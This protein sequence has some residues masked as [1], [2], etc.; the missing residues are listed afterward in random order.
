MYPRAPAITVLAALLAAFAPAEARSQAAPPAIPFAP[1]EDKTLKDPDNPTKIFRVD[2]AEVEYRYPLSR[3]DLMKIT[4]EN[5]QSLQ[6]EQL[7]QIYARLSAGAIPE[8]PYSGDLFFA[9]GENLRARLEEIIGGIRGRVLGGIFDTVELGVQTL[10]KGKVFDRSGRVARTFVENLS[11]LRPLVDDPSTVPTAVIQRRGPLG[12]VVPRN[13]VWV[14]FPAKVFCGQSL[15]DGRR[16]S[17]VIDYAFADEISGYRERPDYLM[18]RYGLNL[19]DEMRMVRPGLY[20]GRAYIGKMFLLNFVLYDRA[21][22]ERD[23]AQFTSGAPVA[24]DCWP[25]EQLR[26]VG[27]K[28]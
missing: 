23:A 25:G 21:L 17:I 13:T 28:P 11:V 1:L 22:M 7:D 12:V 8:G 26:T 3:A 27:A 4:P 10:W 18:T 6:Q 14:L 2:F 24:E 9:K 20:L 16:E 19:R 5:L 15:L